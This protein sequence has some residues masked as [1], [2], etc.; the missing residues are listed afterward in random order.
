MAGIEVIPQIG[1]DLGKDEAGCGAL[2][3]L[4]VSPGLAGGE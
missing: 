4:V 2:E 1:L 3:T